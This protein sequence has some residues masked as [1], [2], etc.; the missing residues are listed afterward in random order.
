M[1]K[2]KKVINKQVEEYNIEFYTLINAF[3]AEIRASRQHLE[4]LQQKQKRDVI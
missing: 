4:Q 3:R 1:N 2:N